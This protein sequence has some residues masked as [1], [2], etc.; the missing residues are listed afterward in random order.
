MPICICSKNLPDEAKQKLS[1]FA[2][3]I[4]FSTSGITYDAISAHPD[5][6]FCKVND[7]IVCA[8]NVPETYKRI[9]CEKNIE[10]VEGANTVVH[11]YPGSAVYNAAVSDS[12]LIHRTDITDPLIVDSCGNLE[13]ITVQ[14]GYTRCSLL[15]L[16]GSSFITSDRGIYEILS[17]RKLNA[18]YVKPDGILLPGFTH[19]FFGGTCG[20]HEDTVFIAGSLAKS[21]EGNS[22]KE[23]LCSLKYDIVELY[24]GPLFDCG[25]LLFI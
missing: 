5:I 23:F 21:K 13:K 6:F 11:T 17:G 25:S 12:F 15:P 3:L 20:V 19:G 22:V 16:K 2:E 8:P 4:E 18:L 9:L 10:L 7:R 24:S 14:Q 1:R